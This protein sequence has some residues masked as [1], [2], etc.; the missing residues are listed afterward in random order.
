MTTEN[1][2]QSAYSSLLHAADFIVAEGIERSRR[3]DPHRLATLP[4][5]FDGGKAV[6]QLAITYMN[7]GKVQVQQLLI[8]TKGGEEKVV[9]V[10]TTT[11]QGKVDGATH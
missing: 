7:G 6:R 2:L 11:L 1:L 4:S 9:A 8:G 3:D 10:F 5:E